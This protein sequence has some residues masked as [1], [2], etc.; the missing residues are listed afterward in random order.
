M[1]EGILLLLDSNMSK[2]GA[3]VGLLFVSA[4]ACAAPQPTTEVG[5]D[6]IVGV[7]Q[8]SVDRLSIG[9]SWLYAE[10]TWVE[11]LHGDAAF[12]ASVSYW[13]YWYWFDQITQ[14][15]SSTIATG[16]NWRTANAIV[17]K[18]G[19]VDR[20]AFG[21][22]EAPRHDAA[23]AAMSASLKDG[24][25]SSL[26]ARKDHVLVRQELDRAWALD[27]TMRGLIDTTFGADVTKN[28]MPYSTQPAP[29]AIVSAKSFPVTYSLGAGHNGFANK[30]LSD[31]MTEWKEIYFSQTDALSF[32][33]RVQNA[34]NDGAPITMSWFVDF[35]ALEE[36]DNGRKGTFNLQ[37]LN[38]LGPGI[39][40]AHSTVLSGFRAKLSDGRTVQSGST[41]AVLLDATSQL[42]VVQVANKWG[43]AHP[44]RP[45][46]PGMPA[47]HDV[48]IDY[49][50]AEV[51]Q[52]SG[53]GVCNSSVVPLENVVLPPGY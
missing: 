50:T 49:L 5:G 45:S 14:G 42:E 3:F 46:E 11:D 36:R 31:A 44:E 51:R 40:G 27:D 41:D 22:D 19:L 13:T 25:L 18:Y 4:A 8:T 43:T 35:N 10:A 33:R 47:V 34:L 38:E 23:I 32:V 48:W 1:V 26:S 2:L 52:C 28:F 6:E 21:N 39:Q 20:S 7:T 9:D 12:H 16:G 53:P 24:A 30:Q 29:S 15:I 17:T 37:T